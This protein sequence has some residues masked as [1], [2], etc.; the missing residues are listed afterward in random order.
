MPEIGSLP[1][2]GA[3]TGA[4]EV[5]ISQGGQAKKT[6]LADQVANTTH[7]SSDGKDHSD[8]VLSN[9]HRAGDGS[10]HADVA[11]NTAAAALNTTH[12]NTTSGNPHSVSKG[13]LSLDT[14]DDVEFQSLQINGDNDADDVAYVRP[15]VFLT[16]GDGDPTPSS[17][18]EG[19]IFIWKEA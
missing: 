19:C 13:D 8:V 6:T 3:I 11:A 4:E 14:D 7:R 5:P 15:I 17:Y 2:A 9:T 1:A 10:D 16:D 18:P 12:R